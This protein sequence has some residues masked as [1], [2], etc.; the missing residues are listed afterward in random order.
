MH[1][2]YS[3]II[4]GNE[5]TL[6]EIESFH[7]TKVLRLRNGDEIKILDGKGTI[8]IASITNT[9]DKRCQVTITKRTCIENPRNYYLHIAIAPTKN[10]ERFE[11]FIE[12]CV[13]VGIDEI[14]PLL[15]D[16]SERKE[17]KKDRIDNIITAAIKQSV[18]PFRPILNDMISLKKFIQQPTEKVKYIAHCNGL[19]KHVK[20][21]YTKGEKSIVLIGPE[22]DFS[23]EEINLCLKMNYIPISLGENRLR[24]E[25]AGVIACSFI[26]LINQ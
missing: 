15:C 22:G 7:C 21:Y 16:H 18:N 12:K 13:E 19:R 11:W 1:L 20:E 23:M 25:T 9:H 6:N 26:N 10:I 3:P 24:T 14:T 5:H 8:C 2:A 17:I 4:E